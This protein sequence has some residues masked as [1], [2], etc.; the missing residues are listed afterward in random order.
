M[1]VA[2]VLVDG[3]DRV[4][5]VVHEVLDGLSVDDLTYRAD[6]QA[7]SIGWLIWHLTR[8]QD[9]QVGAAAGL[10]RVWPE[11]WLQRAELPFPAEENGYGQDPRRVADVRL[12]AEFLAGYHDATHAQTISF[13]RGLRDIDLTRI[14]EPAWDPPV[15]LGVRLVSVI[16]DDLQHAGQAAFIRGLVERL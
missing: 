11:G 2:D 6:V 7:N 4:R 1:S 8:V 15:T 5:E 16:A 12:P 14:V 13:V 3:F 9:D 10:E